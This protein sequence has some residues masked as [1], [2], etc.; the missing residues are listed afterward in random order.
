MQDRDYMAQALA[1]AQ[2]GWGWVSPNPLV[3]AVLVKAGRIIGT[4][5]HARCG[6]A[7]AE[8]AA[9]AACS[10]SPD[11]ATLYVTLEP[12]CHHGRTPPCTQ[13]ILEAGIS[14]VVLGSR[15]P[16]PK[17]HGGGLR[18]LRAAGVE[19]TEGVLQADCD[20][21]NAV[22]FHCITTKTPY[23][24]MKYAMTMDGK[25][26]TVTGASQW[27]TGEVAR[28]HV[29]EDR[30]RYRGILVGV[31]TILADNPR[32]T[33]RMEGGRNPLRILCDSQLRTPLDA[34]VVQSAH[35]IPTLL[36]TCSQ[37]TARAKPYRTAGCELL[38]LP[39]DADGRI[40]LPALMQALGEREID[41]VLLEGGAAL[42]WSALKSGIVQRVQC[43]IAPKL[44]GGASAKSPI[45]GQGVCHPGAAYCL[46][47]PRLTH[48]GEDLLLESEVLPCSQ[49]S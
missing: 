30:H 39:P 28:A 16:N 12:C 15:D 6:E 25:L 11:G 4:G 48:L 14:R 5:Y 23:V 37:D 13:A 43:Y 8:R 20:A 9:L 46:S 44:F 10:E 21:L 32:L 47:P 2:R 27:I 26:A 33:C 36:A 24:V 49:E 40:P 22:F 19:V 31:G 7:H 35:D 1:L 45:G 18:L 3:G 34:F 42:Q 41:S 29:Q 38:S 17:V